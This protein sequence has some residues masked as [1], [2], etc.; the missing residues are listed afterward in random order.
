MGREYNG[1]GFLPCDY[2]EIYFPADRVQVSYLLLDVPQGK[3]ART[4]L[5]QTLPHFFLLA[6]DV[7]AHVP[8]ENVPAILWRET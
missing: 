5:C 2:E 7:R 6:S 4:G 8:P 1:T 3:C